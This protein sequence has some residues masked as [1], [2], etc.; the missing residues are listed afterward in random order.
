MEEAST[1]ACL[2]YLGA[3]APVAGPAARSTRK[4]VHGAGAVCVREHPERPG[5]PR[6][7]AASRSVA[8]R[9]RLSRLPRRFRASRRARGAIDTDTSPRRGRLV[10]GCASTPV[11]RLLR[12][13]RQRV[14]ASRDDGAC[15]VYP[16]ASAPVAGPRRDRH[17]SVSTVRACVCASTPEGPGAPKEPAAS[18]S[19]ARSRGCDSLR[20]LSCGAPEEVSWSGEERRG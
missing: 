10:G 4:R 5:A 19:V 8:R 6:E 7:P 17:A 3:S 1:G 12:R 2:L 14:E 11:D 15:L 13:S 9:R 18:R 20:R 16:G